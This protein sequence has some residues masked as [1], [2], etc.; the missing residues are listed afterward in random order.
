M[1]YCQ[2]VRTILEFNS[3]VWFSSITEEEKVDIERVQKNACKLILREQYVN[4][5][6]A[7]SQ[8][9]LETLTE[10]R[11]KI[12]LKFAK[13]CEKQ[14]EMRDLFTEN[15]DSPYNLRKQEKY[16][17]NFAHTKRYYNSTVPTLQRMLN[18]K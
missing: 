11:D 14:P 9:N 4:Y 5:E 12:A 8:L 15:K 3:N 6:Q 16:N 7:L 10:R 2:F 17:V 18:G 13:K 1:L